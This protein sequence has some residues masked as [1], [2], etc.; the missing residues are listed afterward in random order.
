MFNTLGVTD[1]VT[2]THFPIGIRYKQASVMAIINR[3]AIVKTTILLCLRK[4][5]P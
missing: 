4:L 2:R 1:A 5:K 3:S